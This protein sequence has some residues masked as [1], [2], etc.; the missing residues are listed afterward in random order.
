MKTSQTCETCRY[1]YEEKSNEISEC[2]RYPPR[3]VADP[4]D[5]GLLSA[6][7]PDV[8]PDQWCGEWS[9]VSAGEKPAPT[10]MPSHGVGYGGTRG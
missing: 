10:P 1:F 8:E 4:E 3:P 7:W 2:R 9:L 6:Y 5:A